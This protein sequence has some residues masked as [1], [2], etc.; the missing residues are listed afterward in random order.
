MVIGED[1]DLMLAGKLVESDY[2]SGILSRPR[3]NFILGR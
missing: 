1:K 2:I 3:E